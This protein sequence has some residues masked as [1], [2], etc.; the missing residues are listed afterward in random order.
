MEKDNQRDYSTKIID[1][2]KANRNLDDKKKNN[3]NRRGSDEESFERKGKDKKQVSVY[4][5]EAVEKAKKEVAAK[6]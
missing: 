6:A 4:P 1:K 5:V 3:R 2:Q